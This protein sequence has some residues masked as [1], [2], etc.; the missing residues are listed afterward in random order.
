M[1]STD[2]REDGRVAVVLVEPQGP[3]N[4]G[5]ICRVMRNFGCD[6]LRLV[7]PACNHRALSARHMAVRS[8]DLLEQARLFPTLAQAIADCHLV[9]GTTRRFGKYRQDCCLP[10]DL[11]R[12]L[13]GIQGR[14]ALVF[15][16]EDNGL[17]NAELQQCHRF[18]TIP[19][20]PDLPSMN[21]AQAVT[22]CLYEIAKDRRPPVSP[23][24]GSEQPAPASECEA[25]YAHM[26]AV[27][28]RIGYLNPQ[29]PDHIMRTYRRL[30]GRAGLSTR[31]VRILR[32]LWNAIDVAVQRVD[33][34][35]KSGS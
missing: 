13:A 7:R 14:T 32:G 12:L 8:Q 5:S 22:V 15:G 24:P 27:L 29:N 28:L 30:F 16:R 25:M 20:D 26:Q 10:A 33:K 1:S 2:T 11:P 18:L 6:D 35:R 3:R 17:T 4:I 23:G 34:E 19:T 9:V 31:D 21:L